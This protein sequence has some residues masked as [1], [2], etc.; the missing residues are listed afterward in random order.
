MKLEAVTFVPP[1]AMGSGWFAL[2]ATREPK[3][4]GSEYL[5]HLQKTADKTADS[6]PILS[7]G[8][9]LGADLRTTRLAPARFSKRSIVRMADAIQ[10][11]GKGSIL[12]HAGDDLRRWLGTRVPEL[13]ELAKSVKPTRDQTKS[14]HV[15][16]IETM[17]RDQ[18]FGCYTAKVAKLC[19]KL[20]GC[21][22][23][24]KPEPPKPYPPG[25]FLALLTNP[26][27]Y[28]Y[29]SRIKQGDVVFAVGDVRGFGDNIFTSET[30]MKID[31]TVGSRLNS[32][33]ARPATQ[34]EIEQFLAKA[35]VRALLVLAEIV[36][37]PMAGGG[38]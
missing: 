9:W 31:G 24:Y 11:A 12:E 6:K 10:A 35:S 16:E 28:A 2:T 3:I 18:V 15:R 7:A 38:W 36:E 21:E 37:G 17:L 26:D 4:T 20:I 13:L 27:N 33:N 30:G 23:N 29:T 25:S 32:T 5:V 1:L 22:L 8:M 14:P 34:L 19:G